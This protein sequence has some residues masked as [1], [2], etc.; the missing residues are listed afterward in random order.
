MTATV[1]AAEW[2]LWSTTARLVVTDRRLLGEAR[3]LVDAELAEVERAASRFREDS[4]ISNLAP[5]PDGTVTLSPMLADLVRVALAAARWTDGAVDPTVGTAMRRIGYDR[6][7]R[8]VG[9]G[10]T[11]RAVVRAV[12]GWSRLHLDGDRLTLPAGVEL[13]L[14]AT[15]KAAAADRCAALVHQRL[16][17]GVL[18]S[19]GGDIATAGRAPVAGYWQ[20]RVQDRPEDPAEQVALPA[21]AAIA[22]SS[23]VRR[24]WKRG[25]RTVH[26]IVDPRTGQA[27]EAVWRSV[28][29]ADANCVRANA[30]TTAAL[31]KGR[32]APGWLGSL[33]VPARLLAA[34]CSIVTV[35]AWPSEVAA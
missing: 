26:H 9:D 4:E 17:T 22:T 29:V 15:A 19:L 3:A 5:G 33:G 18:V 31:V 28:T 1:A 32:A 11:L 34:D 25:S 10:P 27:A 2:P 23:T 13:D 20:V 21:G 14:G 30:A 6:D 16:G 8:L 12:P 24:T 35:G 7:L